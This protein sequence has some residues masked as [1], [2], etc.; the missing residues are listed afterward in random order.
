MA[1][2]DARMKA[3]LKTAEDELNL[4]KNQ[5]QQTLLDIREHILDATNPFSSIDDALTDEDEIE[6]GDDLMGGAGAAGAAGADGE[7]GEGGE[8]EDGEDGIDDL[9][10]DDD[11]LEGDD[12]ED[13]EDEYLDD[14]DP[15]DE[16]IEEVPDDGYMGDEIIDDGMGG[17]ASSDMGDAEEVF[18]TEELVPDEDEGFELD[19]EPSEEELEAEAAE[20]AAAE[21]EAN[22]T[23]IG[24]DGVAAAMVADFDV[25][26][27]AGLVRWVAVTTERLGPNRT[28]ILLDAFE[29]AGR[30]APSTRSVLHHLMA[31]SEEDPS[32]IVP[33]REIVSAM[34][35]MEGVLDADSGSDTSR[36]LSMLMDVDDDPMD[37]LLA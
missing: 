11:D 12:A 2:E 18:E 37:R 20:A 3:G 34:V 10:D 13:M 25:L 7:G 35:R 14:E 16:I 17:G 8:G 22:G 31:L 27:M 36:L 28:E 15:G 9:L 32:E 19:E 21:A 1:A 23:A 6:F 26:T 29:A 30:I 4:I 5:V 24:P 33:V